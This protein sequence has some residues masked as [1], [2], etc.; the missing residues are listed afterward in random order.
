MV[1]S[2]SAPALSCEILKVHDPP[3]RLRRRGGGEP[4]VPHPCR[5]SALGAQPLTCLEGQFPERLLA[6]LDLVQQGGRVEDR[7][8]FPQ[9]QRFIQSKHWDEALHRYAK[10]GV[11][12]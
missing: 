10:R 2:Y 7:V 1:R 4:R 5:W 11:V 12:C 6:G 3:E 9:R 8:E